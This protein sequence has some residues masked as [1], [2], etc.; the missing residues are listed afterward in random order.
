MKLKPGQTRDRETAYRAVINMW[1]KANPDNFNYCMEVIK[2]NQLKKAMQSC[3]Y[4]SSKEHP[5]DLR[6]CLNIP[7]GL[8]YTLQKF[9]Q[10]H[11]EEGEIRGFLTS[12]EDSWWFAKHFPQFCCVE[13]V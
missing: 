8:Y 10:M 5:D 4:G 11:A 3:E 2:A 9:E 7:Q 12:K 1:L 13:R 6:V